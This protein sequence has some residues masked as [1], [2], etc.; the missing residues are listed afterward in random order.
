MVTWGVRQ[1]ITWKRKKGQW[2]QGQLHKRARVHSYCELY[3][4]VSVWLRYR[5][6][7]QSLGPYAFMRQTGHGILTCVAVGCPID[8]NSAPKGR[9][10]I[11]EGHIAAHQENMSYGAFLEVLLIMLSMLWW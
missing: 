4:G 7:D 2:Q 1:D 10:A 8:M 9:A 3:C 6:R 11:K 5:V